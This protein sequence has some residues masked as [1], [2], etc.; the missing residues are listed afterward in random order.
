MMYEKFAGSTDVEL[1][2]NRAEALLIVAEVED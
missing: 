1:V 2:N